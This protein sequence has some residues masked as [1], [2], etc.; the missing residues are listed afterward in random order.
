MN[1]PENAM[2]NAC[3]AGTF[4]PVVRQARTPAE[5]LFHRRDIPAEITSYIRSRLGVKADIHP[6]RNNASY[7]GSVLLN[8]TDWLVQTVGRNMSAA[9]VHR[10]ADVTLI[11]AIALRDR[12]KRLVGASIQVHYNTGKAKAYPLDTHREQSNPRPQCVAKRAVEMER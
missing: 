11:G 7:K 6:A 4:A 9:V 12:S 8:A 5:H 3:S 1:N 2:R 10:K